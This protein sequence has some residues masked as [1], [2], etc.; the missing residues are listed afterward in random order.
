MIS[1]LAGVEASISRRCIT[2]CRELY[3]IM[4]FVVH[5]P[6]VICIMRFLLLTRKS[7]ATQLNFGKCAS[8]DILSTTATLERWCDGTLCTQPRLIMPHHSSVIDPTVEKRTRS[9]NKLSLIIC[10]G[11]GL[12]CAF[13]STVIYEIR[14]NKNSDSSPSQ[15]TST[16]IDTFILLWLFEWLKDLNL[17][18]DRRKIVKNKSH[19]WKR[20]N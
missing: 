5:K 3:E 7:L 10:D 19:K 4:A 18:D 14:A 12:W 2:S 15:T 11:T 9:A 17:W 16:H 6:P 1:G 8:C 20:R 13:M